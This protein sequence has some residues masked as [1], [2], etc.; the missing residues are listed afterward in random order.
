MERLLMSDA[1][2]SYAHGASNVPLV[3]STIGDVFDRVANSRPERE[4]LVS[5]HQNLRYTYRQLQAEVDRFARGL[6]ALGI[7]SGDRVGIWSPNHAEW[8][9]TQF[10]TAK[11]GAILVNINPAYRVHEL[12]YVL[13]QS[14]CS[15]LII[16]PRLKSTDYAALLRDVCP[17]LDRDRPGQLRSARVPYLRSVIAFG[18]QRL[19]GAYHWEDVL[20]SA[21]NVSAA[22]LAARQCEQQFDA[23]INIQ[24]TSGT[25][26]FP[27]GATLSHHSILNNTI[28]VARYLGFTEHDR[29]CVTFP[30]YHCAGMGVSTLFCVVSGATMVIPAPVFEAGATLETVERERCTGLHGVPT[31]FIA[32]LNH[33]DFEKFDLSS[34]RAGFMGGSP[35]PIEVMKQVDERMGMRDFVIGYGMTE[36]SPVS[37]MTSVDDALDK[38][39]STVGRPFPHVECKI[40]DP[41]TG[42]VVER[43]E[44][45][46]L[47]VRGYH[48]MLGYWNDP[49]ATSAAIDAARWMHTGDLATMDEDG[50]LNIVGRSKDMII[51]G[52]ENVY[53]REVE[54]FLYEHPR[55]QDVQVVGVPD[56][57]YGEEIMAWIVLKPGEAPTTDELREYCQDQIAHYK[58][59]RY[60]KFVDAFPMTVSGKVQKFRLREIAINE[61]GLQQVAAIRTA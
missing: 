13:N 36:T 12:E 22:A 19:Q 55:V 11:I 10:A 49:A 37:T 1:R 8:V 31:M 39:V 38:R 29:L 18:Q 41:A 21:P 5:R 51:R 20:A 54:E 48:L 59:P 40:V 3:A 9:V 33:P 60:W 42:K 6:M 58:I 43:G 23:P 15:A 57:K 50:Y 35:C 46:E 16:A 26:G 17:E 25:T 34:L 14:G 45:G 7:Q 24:Y 30:Y 52:G 2:L 47:L 27:K 4:A 56:D 28:F 61:L 44:R 32:E 53:P